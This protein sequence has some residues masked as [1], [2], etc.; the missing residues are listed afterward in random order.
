M[1]VHRARRSAAEY[2]LVKTYSSCRILEAVAD[3]L[4]T[5]HEFATYVFVTSCFPGI[6]LYAK[7]TPGSNIIME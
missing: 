5:V 1:E 2:D 4:E 7:N 3:M 6:R